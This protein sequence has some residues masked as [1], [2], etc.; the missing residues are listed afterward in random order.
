MGFLLGLQV[1]DLALIGALS[2]AWLYA[3][4]HS[5]RLSILRIVFLEDEVC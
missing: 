1:P 5:R 3:S 4:P 2:K